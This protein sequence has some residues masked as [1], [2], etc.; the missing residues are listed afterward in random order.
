M[1]DHSGYAVLIIL[2]MVH[3]SIDYCY[4]VG[5]TIRPEV[6]KSDYRDILTIVP[7]WMVTFI[8]VIKCQGQITPI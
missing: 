4:T 7:V 8:N 3:D 6:T 5:C 2:R 1:T